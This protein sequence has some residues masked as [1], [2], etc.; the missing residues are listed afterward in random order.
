MTCALAA[1]CGF[2]SILAPLTHAGPPGVPCRDSST[3]WCLLRTASLIQVK[4]DPRCTICSGAGEAR[5][6]TRPSL[7]RASELCAFTTS[8]YDIPRGGMCGR[9]LLI[10]SGYSTHA[11]GSSTLRP[12][13]ERM[14]G[15]RSVV[16]TT[17]LKVGNDL[18][19]NRILQSDRIERYT[20]DRVTF[21]ADA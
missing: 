9:D 18:L 13:S 19:S 1:R 2:L 8:I 16:W 6:M 10:S 12:M 7:K 17:D 20:Q 3:N 15:S 11:N 21:W 5:P 14:G 4:A